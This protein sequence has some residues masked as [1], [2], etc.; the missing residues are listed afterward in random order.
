VLSRVADSLYWLSRY[1]ERAEH[2]AR[3]TSVYL[4]IVLDRSGR[5]GDAG[6]YSQFKEILQLD[7]SAGEEIDT[8]LLI[9]STVFDANNPRS[10]VYAINMARENARQVR[11]Q[12]STETW[13]QINQLYLLMQ[14]PP[15]GLWRAQPQMFM[16]DLVRNFY[17]AGGIGDATMSHNEGWHFMRLGGYMERADSIVHLL[18]AYFRSHT[19]STDTVTDYL[20]MVALLRCFTA[21]EAY[22]NVYTANLLPARVAEFLLLNPVFP[23]SLRFAVNKMHEALQEI[24]ILTKSQR[25]DR[26]NRQ[27]GRLQ[28]QLQFALIEEII[29]GGLPTFL[30]DV[31]GQCRRIHEL[32]YQVYISFPVAEELTL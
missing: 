16:Q 23:H 9:E 25:N 8:R 24:A 29:A 4:D 14:H 13:V 27:A 11:E 7:S 1:L 30:Q 21:F 5:V 6:R 15:E 32:T 28:S 2:T 12:I 19:G 26:L 18:N 17:L 10:I 31:Q 20:E 22:C 3:I